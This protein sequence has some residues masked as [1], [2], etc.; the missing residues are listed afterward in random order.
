MEKIKSVLHGHGHKKVD[1]VAEDTTNPANTTGSQDHPIYDQMTT[2]HTASPYTQP[3][4]TSGEPYTALAQPG[5]AVHGQ[6]QHVG[7]DGPIGDQSATAPIYSE[8]NQSTGQ[9]HAKDGGKASK[10][11]LKV[12]EK[13]PESVE[14]A[15]PN[16][17]HDTGDNKHSTTSG[18]A[19]GTTA[20]SG[21]RPNAS[22]TGTGQH[23]E[24]MS[25]ASI[26][27]GVIGF[28]PGASQ[29]HAARSTHNPTEQNMEHDQVLGGGV[30]GTAGRT[31]GQGLQ[32]DASVQPHAQTS[33]IVDQSRA[34]NLGQVSEDRPYDSTLRQESYTADTNRTFPLAG[35]VT[36]QPHEH[37]STT[38]HTEEPAT[39]PYAAPTS[40][41]HQE[42]VSEREPGTKEKE[43]GVNDGHGR[44]ALAGAAAAAAG[45]GAASAYSHRDRDAQEPEHSTTSRAVEPAST[46][47]HTEAEQG[48]SLL[49]KGKRLIGLGG[50][51]DDHSHDQ[52]AVPA[53]TSISQSQGP[54]PEALAAAQAA[55]SKSATQQQ[56]TAG[57]DASTALSGASADTGSRPEPQRY[58]SQHRH[59]P[60]EFIATPHEHGGNTYL[61][62]HNVVEPPPGTQHNIPQSS[63]SVQTSAVPVSGLATTSPATTG[64][65]HS[66]AQP[67]HELRHTGTLDEPRPRSSDENH[68]T[69]N[70][71]LGAGAIGLGAAAASHHH[72]T[73]KVAGDNTLPSET[74]PYSS[75]T[76]DPRVLGSSAPLDQQRF[77]P[78]AQ[79]EVSPHHAAQ[80]SNPAGFTS[81]SIS[82]A[83]APQETT[84]TDDSQHHYGRDAALVGAGAAAAGGLAAHHNNDL[85]P[86]SASAQPVTGTSAPVASSNTTAPLASSGTAVPSTS[87]AG[88]DHFYGT[89]G[90]PA[91]VVDKN[92]QSSVPENTLGSTGTTN[93]AAAPESESHHG[94]NAALGGAGLAAA[95]TGLYAATRDRDNEAT[96]TSSTV[97]PG[98]N[99]HVGSTTEDPASHTI[100]PHKSNIA[101][102]LD[103]RVKPDPSKQKEHATS[104]PHQSDTLNKLDPRVDEKAAQQESHLG[105]DAAIA[106]GAGAGGY[107]AYEAA[108]AYTDHRMTQPAASM[109]EQRY[110]PSTR[111]GGPNPVAAKSEYDYNDPA[112][113]SNVNRGVE[114]DSHHNK[115]LSAGAGLGAAGLAAGAYAGSRQGDNTQ[116]LPIHDQQAVGS[117]TQPG[118]TSSAL[119]AHSTTQ[120]TQPTTQH[121]AKEDESHTGRNAAL[122]GG[123]GAAAGAG[124]YALSQQDDREQARLAERERE[125]A[126]KE[127]KAHLKEEKKL[128]KEQE[129]EQHKQDKA[130]AKHDREVKK[131]D[132]A[133]AAHAKEEKKLQKEA[134]KEEKKA[135]K[136]EKKAQKE[137]EKE[138]KRAQKEAE[139][140]EKEKK[141]GILGFLHR[142]KSK[143]EKNSSS[144]ESSPR[145]SRESSRRSKEYAAGAGALGAGTAAAAYSDDNNPSSPRY[146]AHNKLHKDPPKGHPAREALENPAPTT[147]LAS[148]PADTSIGKRE[149]VGIDGPIGDPASISGDRETRKGVFGAHPASDLDN[150]TTVIEPRT[151]LPMNVGRYGEGAGG[152]DG[153]MAIHGLE[154]SGVGTTTGVG[155]GA[156]GESQTATGAGTDWEAIRKAN[157]PY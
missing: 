30:A 136:E 97:A 144:P 38:A 123:A 118:A 66:V 90:A 58:E 87:S 50:T 57:N 13:L 42:T 108:K 147:G 77:D 12:Q 93:T 157:T 154:G 18:A 16:A 106:G 33:S 98:S 153:N 103:P 47:E 131:H 61:D 122:L 99:Q 82:G 101:N 40:T 155:A 67:Q 1:S 125:M 63:T 139:K 31:E 126:Q 132:A 64:N 104:G 55:V 84:R 20:A 143:R 8:N 129:R 80:T 135:E 95:G 107:G 60:G 34:T 56:P 134:E 9:T 44:E 119:P 37:A 21:L 113:Q 112:V 27:S 121:A 85:A 151:G 35:G 83:S 133:V 76:M 72:N 45:V 141:G 96:A 120:T 23:G 116:S 6:P 3:K 10:L 75:K 22:T 49:E 51:K 59:I 145:Q 24:D 156:V 79:S 15:A 89:A 124:A 110:D 148:D 2:G 28:G 105:R 4:T 94:R 19:A 73:D 102:V 53:S 137:A 146:K 92:V 5:S 65:D 71:A 26:K 86:T 149:H 39:T 36:S 54:H 111:T 62:Y 81:S 69:R 130:E 109:N 150:D 91:P 32:S 88:H 128:H 14:R 142:D 41:L 152:T 25:T 7:I 138:E 70:A 74:S 11:P 78:Q 68:T 140:E 127:E 115:A 100:G 43:V 17:I 46:T 52:T 29:G 48:E 117:S 114:S